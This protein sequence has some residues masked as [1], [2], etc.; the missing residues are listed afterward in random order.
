MGTVLWGVAPRYDSLVDPRPRL[1]PAGD[2][3]DGSA[4]SPCDLHEHVVLN[5]RRDR[6]VAELAPRVH[7]G[8]LQI[9]R[10][11]S[12]EPIKYLMKYFSIKADKETLADVQRVAGDVARLEAA[13]ENVQQR[14]SEILGRVNPPAF[15]V[16]RYAEE[17]WS[18][19]GV[20]LSP[21]RVPSPHYKFQY[22][23]AGGNSGQAVDIWLDTPT[24][25]AL[26][27]TLA[28]KI[29][30]AKSAAGQRSL[31]TAQLRNWIKQRDNYACRY[32]GVSVAAEPH[33]LLEVDHIIP[34]SQGGLSVPENL[35]A[36]WWKCNRSKG[37]RLPQGYTGEPSGY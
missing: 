30:W 15:I 31:M 14:E 20:H 6:N 29:R 19:I 37:A 8:S 22:T 3:V 27:Q 32:C 5:N 21:I 35:Q 23:S 26:S 12:M 28:D 2:V 11:A 17:F 10:N 1:L 33:L 4:R 16:K 25:D 9:V 34:I 24:L 36:L 13:V 7:N 18:L